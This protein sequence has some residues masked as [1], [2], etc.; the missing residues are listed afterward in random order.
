MVVPTTLYPLLTTRLSHT[1]YL[2]FT[3][4][5]ILFTHVLI[6][7]SISRVFTCSMLYF[8][9]HT[10]YTYLYTR[11]FHVC[12]LVLCAYFTH[13]LTHIFCLTLYMPISS[14]H[15]HSKWHLDLAMTVGFFRYLVLG[16]ICWIK[17]FDYLNK[18]FLQLTN[19][20][21]AFGIYIGIFR[22]FKVVP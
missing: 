21:T 20:L 13:E 22:H 15:G 1:L 14:I 2:C 18:F 12:L 9:V 3:F 11:L 8:L 4:L 17:L 10:F 6:H 16:C 7:A 5:Y 19:F